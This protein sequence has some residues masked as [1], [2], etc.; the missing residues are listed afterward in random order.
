MLLCA[1]CGHELISNRDWKGK[2][3]EAA[4]MQVAELSSSHAELETAETVRRGNY[5]VPRN[6]LAGDCRRKRICHVC[7]PRHH[8]VS[9]AA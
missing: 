3:G 1:A 8:T 6:H 9:T 7:A 5:T 4:S 2:I